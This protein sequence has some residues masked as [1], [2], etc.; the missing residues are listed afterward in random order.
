MAIQRDIT[1]LGLGD[2]QQVGAHTGQADGL[3]GRRA[4]IRHRHLFEIEMVDSKERGSGNQDCSKRAHK[5][6][7][8]L[9]MRQQEKNADQGA[10]DGNERSVCSPR[11]IQGSGCTLAST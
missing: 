6:I 10:L 2:L 3:R 8:A 9:K 5:K 1:A 11:G 4:F 7:V